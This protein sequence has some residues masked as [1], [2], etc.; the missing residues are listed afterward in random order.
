MAFS[1]PDLPYAYDALEP[2]IDEATMHVHHDKHHQAYVNKANAALEGTEWADREVEDVLTQPLHRARR[3]PGPG[4]EQR[5]RP[6]QPLAVLGDAAAP[7]AAASRIGDL[8]EA[9]DDRLRVLRHVQG[10]VQKRRH[11]PLRLRLGL[12][13]ARRERQLVVVTMPNQDCPFSDGKRAAARLRRLG[14]RLLPQVSEPPPRLHRRLLER[15]QLG[16]GRAAARRGELT[17][18]LRP[19]AARPRAGRAALR[20]PL[21][22]SWL[23][24]CSASAVM[25]RLGLTPTLAG[26]AAPRRRAGSRSRRRAGGRRRHHP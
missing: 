19:R 23:I 8:A 5:R 2:H 16:L 24:A 17:L 22:G 21:V 6:L 4:A 1:V 26:I 15:R 12:A 25:V 3:Q 11:R 13:G 18:T 9:I 7:M 14:A 20:R 10:G